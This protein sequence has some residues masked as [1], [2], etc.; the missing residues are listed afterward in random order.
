[1]FKHRQLKNKKQN[2][3][4]KQFFE[5]VLIALNVLESAEL[6]NSSRESGTKTV[7]QELFKNNT[8][9]GA[10]ERWSR[11]DLWVG[12]IANCVTA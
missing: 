3:Q 5:F 9:N 8:G 6:M 12:L 2:T 4:T 11:V 7:L 1:M 10:P